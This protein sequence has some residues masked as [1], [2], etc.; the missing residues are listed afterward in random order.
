MKYIRVWLAGHPSSIGRTIVAERKPR[1]SAF[2]DQEF[3]HTLAMVNVCVHE[4]PQFDST[5]VEAP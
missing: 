3:N 4:E 2:D 5:P 1:K